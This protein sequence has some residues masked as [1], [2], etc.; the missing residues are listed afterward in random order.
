[1]IEDNQTPLI[2]IDDNIP[3]IQGRLEPFCRTRYVAQNDFSPETV[4]DADAL[5]IRTRTRCNNELL[6]GSNVK[7]IATAT[8][9]MD[10]FNL[11]DCANLGIRTYNAPGC[12]APAVAQYVWSAI[13]NLGINPKEITLGIVGN[14]NIGSIVAEW[15]NLL[16]TKVMISD[17]PQEA[18]SATPLKD[19]YPLHQIMQQA[20]VITLHVP[21]TKDGDYPTYHLIGAKEVSMMKQGALLINAA[22]GPVLDT[23]PVRQAVKEGKIRTVIDCWE[24]EPVIDSDLLELSEFATFHIAGYSI[25]GKQRATRMAIS[26]IAE[27]FGFN[28]DLSGLA[29]PYV[30]K[31]TLDTEKLRQALDF[32][33]LTAQLRAEPQRFDFMRGKYPLRHES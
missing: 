32:N 1:M 29:E 19:H 14:G 3:Y 20:D 5:I 8:V 4:K 31:T 2:V 22:R 30:K 12:N 21:M 9:G 28:P 26:R 13:L 16:G 33:S 7:I 6:S 10:Q 25:E 23:I 11:A 24:G 18:Q 15:A 17:P 27:F